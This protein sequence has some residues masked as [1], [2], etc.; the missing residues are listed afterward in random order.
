MIRIK[1]ILILFYLPLNLLAQK[2]Y[3]VFFADKNQSSFSI[4]K[5]EE[6]LSAASLERRVKHAIEVSEED[7]PVCQFY[8]DS[9]DRSGVQVEYCSKWLNACLVQAES[10]VMESIKAFSF[11]SSYDSLEKKGGWGIN[12]TSMSSTLDYGNSFDQLNLHGINFMH[13]EGL[14]GQGITIAVL[15]AGFPGVDNIEAFNHIISENRIKGTFDFPDQE[16]NVFDDNDHGTSVLSAIAAYQPGKLIGSSYEADLILLRTEEVAFESRKE[17]F[18]WLLGAEY[19][20][21]AGADIISSS[22]GYSYFDNPSEDYTYQD[23]NGR[24]ALISYA[25]EKAFYKG[26]LVVNSAGNEG[27][28]SW[29]YINAPADAEHVLAVGATDRFGTYY[30]V[31][32]KGPSS[33]GRIKPDV[34]SVGTSTI[35]INGSGNVVPA[36]GTSFSAPIISGFA[37]NCWQ[38][39]PELKNYELLQ[40]IKQS[41]DNYAFPDNKRGYGIPSFQKF[42]DLKEGSQESGVI[43]AGNPV[44]DEIKFIGPDKEEFRVEL[45]DISGRL[46]LHTHASGAGTVEVSNLISGIYIVVF[47]FENEAF[48]F[49]VVKE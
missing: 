26:M 22:L 18:Y 42:K 9:I 20:D 17:E 19:A 33:D 16:T 39:Y 27:R 32:S 3:L 45:F 40:L 15:D 11:V 49:V 8:I 14:T 21:S 23:L 10:D 6:F 43:L 35:T 2:D 13:Q 30:E 36:N 7:L 28:T 34:L 12:S 37:A 46:L 31:S 29:Y 41:S 5:S 38:K 25:A 44:Q 24:V 47:N 48:R 1:F 4:L